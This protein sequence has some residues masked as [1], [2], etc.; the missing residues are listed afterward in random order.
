MIAR[1]TSAIVTGSLTTFGLFFL[2]QA[3]IAMQPG[4]ASEP[5]EPWILNVVRVKQPEELKTMEFEPID[6]ALK[7]P[8]PVA[9]RPVDSQG[10]DTVISLPPIAPP[11]PA[12]RRSG[13]VFRIN[14]GPPIAIVRVQPVYPAVAEARG[15]EGWVLVEFDVQP[16]GGVANAFIVESSNRIFEKA[17][18]RATYRF[19][20]KP[21][22]VDGVPQRTVGV[23]NLFRFEISDE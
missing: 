10:G 14:D 11:L 2:M 20:F 16:D 21:R 19:R 9:P 3:L 23:Q 6:K 15:L 7:D 17:A 22:V 8:P 4:A 13:T 1:Y 18:L 5:R 12:D